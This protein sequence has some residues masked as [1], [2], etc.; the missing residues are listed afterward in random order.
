M[1][2]IFSQS[3]AGVNWSARPGEEKKNF[4]ENEALPL[5]AA[6]IADPINDAD[7]AKVEKFK[8]DRDAKLKKEQQKAE[9][10]SAVKVERATAEKG[11]NAQAAAGK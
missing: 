3:I 5:C 6:G 9:K 4:P 10:A 2:I 7:V 11:E 8:K 1:D